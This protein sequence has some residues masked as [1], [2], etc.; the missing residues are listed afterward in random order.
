MALAACR[1]RRLGKHSAIYGLGGLVSRMIAVFLLPLYTRYLDRVRL[2]RSRDRRRALGRA[3]HD[4]AGSGSRRRS[5]A[6][7]STPRTTARRLLVAAHVVLVHDGDRDARARRPAS[8]LAEPDRR[9]ASGSTTPNL[10]RAGFVALWAQMNYEQLTVALPRRGALGR[11]RAREPGEHRPHDRRHACC[12]SSCSEQG[13]ARRDRRQ[14]RGHARRLPR[15]ARRTGASSSG[16]SSTAAAPA[17][18]EPL[19]VPLVPPRSL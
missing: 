7:T 16:S 5:S 1:C 14:L 3:G 17:R 15:A 13:R 9:P 18:D 12:S 11:V 10:V 6:S 4:P 2:R 8:L 19:R